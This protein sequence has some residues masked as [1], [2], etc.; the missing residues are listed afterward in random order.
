MKKIGATVPEIFDVFTYFMQPIFDLEMED[1]VVQQSAIV[2][3][4]SFVEL[5]CLYCNL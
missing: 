5:E 2:S 4:I 3:Q 1:Y